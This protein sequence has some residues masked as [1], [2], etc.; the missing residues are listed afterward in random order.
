M[1]IYNCKEQCY[2]QM[3]S[4]HVIQLQVTEEFGEICAAFGV[5]H[6]HV[7]TDQEFSLQL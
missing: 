1:S 2:M 7:A 6:V 3:Y 4:V 5:I